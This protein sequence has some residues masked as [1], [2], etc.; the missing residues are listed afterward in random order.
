MDAIYHD[1]STTGSVNNVPTQ[2]DT[3]SR[4]QGTMVILLLCVGLALV[5]WYTFEVSAGF[6]ERLQTG[7][8]RIDAVNEKINAPT[9][10]EYRIESF[11]DRSF[12]QRINAMGSDG[13]EL[14]FARRASDGSEYSPTF[15]YEMIF[16]RPKKIETGHIDKKQKPVEK[17]K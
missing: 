7:I 4:F 5:G 17:N 10:W 15:S 8:A 16:K 13:W 2:S 9:Q 14:V 6:D 11:P 12:D 3:M 1:Q